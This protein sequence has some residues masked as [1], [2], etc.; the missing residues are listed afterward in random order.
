MSRSVG[1]ILKRGFDLVCSLFGLLVALPFL[2]VIALMIKIES[3]RLPLFYKE[4]RAGQ[5]GQP[6][7]MFKFRTMLPHVIDYDHHPEVRP[8]DPR[9]T[10]VGAFLRRFLLDELPQL[11]NVVLGQMS[12]VGPRPM[13]LHKTARLDEFQR[14]RLL[15]KP[16]MTGW[17]QVNGNTLLSW[18]DRIGMDIWY[19]A[20]WSLGLDAVIL[21][22]TVELALC[23]ER[24]RDIG[25]K[26]NTDHCYRLAADEE[27]LSDSK[28]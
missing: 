11:L 12:L 13:D 19:I 17:A 7:L 6:F 15:F 16:G 23:G 10:R 2:I 3:P 9:V 14:Q 27:V 8:G 25:D 26:P 20:H 18:A 4:Y 5:Y 28:Q 22:R 21:L 24:L 1:L